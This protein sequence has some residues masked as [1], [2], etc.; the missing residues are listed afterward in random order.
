MHTYTY[1]S[2]NIPNP[3]T[4]NPQLPNQ[5]AVAYTKRRTHP[6]SRLSTRMAASRRVCA[7]CTVHRAPCTLHPA[8]C[9]LHPEP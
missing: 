4:P 9:T 1:V 3:Q 8:P 2:I 7:P 6:G 5:A